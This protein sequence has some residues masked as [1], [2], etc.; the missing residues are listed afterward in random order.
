MRLLKEF[1]SAFVN[2]CAPPLLLSNAGLRSGGGLGCLFGRLWRHLGLSWRRPWGLWPWGGGACRQRRSPTLLA[3][4]SLLGF[5]GAAFFPPVF[6]SW[7]AFA[8]V[9]K[10]HGKVYSIDRIFATRR[11]GPCI[12]RFNVPLSAVVSDQR[13]GLSRLGFE[14]RAQDLRNCHPVRNAS[15]RAVAWAPRGRY[16]LVAG[17]RRRP[18]FDPASS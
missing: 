4:A 13:R 8:L 18:E 16:A 12:D 9:L 1:I 5:S 10:P 11:S 15:P 3:Y 17:R 7:L 14:P 2:L 6:S